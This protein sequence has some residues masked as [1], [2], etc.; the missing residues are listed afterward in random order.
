MKKLLAVALVMLL[1]LASAVLFLETPPGL[2]IAVA[3]PAAASIRSFTVIVSSLGFNGSSGPLYINVSQGDTVQIT[4]I[5]DDGNLSFDNSHQIRIEG[6]GPTTQVLNRENPREV[7]TF[8]A[9]QAGLF[10]IHC[11]I[12]CF[13]MQNMQ[14]GWLAVKAPHG[15]ESTGT[16]LSIVSAGVNR[17][18]VLGLAVSLKDQQGNP[19]QGVLV[20]FYAG[21]DQGPEQ[22][23][24]SSTQADGTA[25]LYYQLPAEGQVNVTCSF[26]GNGAYGAS[27]ASQV[28]DTGIPT[29]TTTSA[30]PFVAGQAYSPD[31]RLVGSPPPVSD[32]IAALTLAAVA[33]VWAVLLFAL[34]SV[35][36][37]VARNA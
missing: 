19:V 32:A 37:G 21:T 17:Q 5:W 34:F 28:I 4:F 16:T 33:A 24:S 31:V 36:R 25:F 14:Q 6:Y 11:I 22:I 29:R 10:N 8:V 18:G 7:V 3:G 26:P 1:P 27:S 15:K 23:G 35:V 30:P 9:G 12:P 13:G 20:D 2:S